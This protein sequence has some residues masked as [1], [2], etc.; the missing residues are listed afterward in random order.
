MFKKVILLIASLLKFGRLVN[1]F[2][3]YSCCLEA[4]IL[5]VL[6]LLSYRLIVSCI[7]QQL[8]YK[9]KE[10]MILDITKGHDQWWNQEASMKKKTSGPI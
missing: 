8:K 1:S 5:V 9:G 6:F 4:V 10:V 3:S 7:E 2:R